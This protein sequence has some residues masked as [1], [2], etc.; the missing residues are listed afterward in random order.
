MTAVDT[1][2]I[3]LRRSPA[4]VAAAVFVIAVLVL[5]TTA[6]AFTAPERAGRVMD[7]AGILDSDTLDR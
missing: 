5:T 3:K 7:E 1:A 4:F 2:A 6:F